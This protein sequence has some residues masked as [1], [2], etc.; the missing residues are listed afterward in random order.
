MFDGLLKY[1]L[2][3]SVEAFST[4]RDA[5]L[6]YPVIQGHQVHGNRVAIITR[7]GMTREELEGYVMP[8]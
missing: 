4:Q 1:D 5:Q 6:P 2:G 7:A 3:K 8:S